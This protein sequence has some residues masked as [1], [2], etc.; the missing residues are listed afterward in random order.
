[1]IGAASRAA[2]VL[3]AAMLGGCGSTVTLT[4]RDGGPIGVGV[5]PGTM[6]GHGALRIDLE[7]QRY[8]GEWIVSDEGGF[9]GYANPAAAG[10]K[11]LGSRSLSQAKGVM[12]AKFAGNGD[13]RAYANAPDGLALKCNFHFNAV[14]QAAQGLCERSD[15]KLYD[16]VMK[17]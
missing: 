17:Q 15:G 10:D 13:G 16:L 7:G 9:A 1:M 5:S 11:M 8:V 14:T 4:P 2:A 6:G 12:A 3:M